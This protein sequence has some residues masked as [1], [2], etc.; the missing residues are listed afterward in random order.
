MTGKELLLKAKL[1]LEYLG[2]P[3]AIA[4]YILVNDAGPV[5]IETGPGS[6]VSVSSRRRSTH[7]L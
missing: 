4:A 3:G 5:M 7:W 6:A 1:D 2:T